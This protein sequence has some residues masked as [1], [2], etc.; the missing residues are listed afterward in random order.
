MD[1]DHEAD[2]HDAPRSKVKGEAHRT[3]AEDPAEDVR[4][5]L[6]EA[7]KAID[8]KADADQADAPTEAA[9][10]TGRSHR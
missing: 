2:K 8:P 4:H 9:D 10:T 6:A 1:I 5:T 7:K 3:A